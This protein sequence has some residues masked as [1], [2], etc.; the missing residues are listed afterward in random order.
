MTQ[1]LRFALVV[2]V[3]AGLASPAAAIDRPGFSNAAA[4][5]AVIIHRGKPALVGDTRGDRFDRR[6]ER[7][8]GG[9]VYLGERDYQGD[10]AWQSDSFND[11]WHERPGRNTPRW[12]VSN[13]CERQ[14]WTGAG[15][16]C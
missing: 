1:L 5:A 9:L 8:F 15:W 11:W 4:G 10:T 16:R 2:V 13:N 3:T 12:L 6:R 7:A 14:Y